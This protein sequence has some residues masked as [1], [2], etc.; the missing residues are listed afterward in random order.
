MALSQ[1]E[2][3]ALL[4]S[5][6]TVIQHYNFMQQ[7][8]L[9]ILGLLVSEASPDLHESLIAFILLLSAQQR[10]AYEISGRFYILARSIEYQAWFLE[11]ISRTEP[12][13]FKEF[14]RISPTTFVYLCD[15][16]REDLTTNPPSGLDN[17]PNRRFSVER[18][19]AIAL[20]RYAAGDSLASLEAMFGC[21]K[22]TISKVFWRFI[23]ALIHRAGPIHFSWPTGEKME[24]VKLGMK[25]QQGFP[26]CCG[27][28]DGTHF[29]V[30]LP[31]GQHS[32]AFR[33]YKGNNSIALQAIVDGNLRF[34]D[35]FVGWSG[36]IHDTRLLR[37][38]QFFQSAQY[39]HTV[40][41]G[42]SFQGNASLPIREYIVGDGGYPVRDWLVVPYP[43]ALGRREVFNHILSSTRMCVERAF[44]K[45]KGS[46][47][48]LAKPINRPNVSRL[49][50]T[51]YAACILH[52]IVIDKGDTID[53][54]VYRDMPARP[55]GYSS[56]P[57]VGG[58]G[59]GVGINGKTRNLL[60][61][62]LA[63]DEKHRQKFID[64]QQF[65]PPPRPPRQ[66][67]RTTATIA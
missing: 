8:L 27:A 30:E 39:D 11:D 29:L 65:D 40:L 42:P 43:A 20:R 5:I 6:F 14:F 31:P 25:L 56:L 36:S 64:A 61:E 58:G 41:N 53:Q 32:T 66:R 52:N 48:L 37:R 47:R 59:E 38:S 2:I 60:M 62:H 33:D 13:R 23:Q 22:S 35:L 15:L 63:L 24:V 28:I 57:I 19:I 51:I 44:G 3:W 49:G 55:L 1:E 16:L 7:E 4:L 45:L 54:R 10:R 67:R 17:L 12:Q 9:A 34:L 18:Q 21:S 46:W 26:N 50:E